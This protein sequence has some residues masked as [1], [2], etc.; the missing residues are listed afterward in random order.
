MIEKRV[1]TPEEF[2]TLPDTKGFELVAGLIL[3]KAMGIQASIISVNVMRLLSSYVY[4]HELGYVMDSDAGYRLSEDRPRNVRKPDV[5]FVARG[6]FPNEK[7]PQGYAELAPDLAVEVISP[8]D[9]ADDVEKKRKEYLDA[10]VRLIWVVHPSTEIV[11]TYSSNGECACLHGNDEL[12]GDPVIAGFS[13][14]VTDLFSTTL[15]V[16]EQSGGAF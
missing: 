9:L 4:A 2:E 12:Q 14:R 3:E 5:S 15:P 6:R 16:S 11:L 10:G 8:N 7:I 1:F 13:C